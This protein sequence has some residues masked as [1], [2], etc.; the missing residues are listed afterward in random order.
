MSLDNANCPHGCNS[1]GQVLLPNGIFDECPIHGRKSTVVLKDVR[2]ENGESLY[3]V[4]QIPVDYQGTLISDIE[5]LFKNPDIMQNCLK[6]SVIQLKDILYELYNI[7]TVEN[8][9]LMNSLYV[10]ANPNLIDLREFVYTIL[11]VAFENNISVLPAT[12]INDLS[13]LMAL[14]DYSSVN[15]RDVKDVRYISKLNTLAGQGA[16]WAFRTHLTYSDYLSSSI[17]IIFDNSSTTEGNLEVFQ[18]FLE[19]RSLRGLPTYV[20]STCF[21]DNKRESLF[22]DRS[23]RRKLGYLTPYLLLGKSQELMAREKGWLI[24]TDSENSNSKLNALGRYSSSVFQTAKGGN[25]FPL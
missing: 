10:Y 7:I 3:D 2:L 21:F 15:L 1:R 17:C 24:K 14:Q 8:N 18:G 12:T 23:G 6:A 9:I 13:G 16:D 11:Q 20:F 22:Y 4:L 25:N 5:V 19:E